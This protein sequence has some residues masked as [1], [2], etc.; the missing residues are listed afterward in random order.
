MIYDATPTGGNDHSMGIISVSNIFY[1]LA[2]WVD[3]WNIFPRICQSRQSIH[4]RFHNVMAE[5]LGK[6]QSPMLLCKR[7]HS[8]FDTILQRAPTYLN[9]RAH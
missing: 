2:C 3:G 8:T 1:V 5:H 4:V 7:V 6:S 9:H